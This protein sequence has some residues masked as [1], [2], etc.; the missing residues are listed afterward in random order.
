[1]R[2]D[3]KSCR[4]QTEAVDDD[5]AQRFSDALVS[6]IKAEMGRRDLSSRKL[7]V[8]IGES[9]Q[10]MSMRLDGGNP[11][12]GVRVL[13]NV[14]DIAAIADALGIDAATLMARAAAAAADEPDNVVRG[15]FDVRASPEDE[16]DAVARRSDPEPT[17][18]Q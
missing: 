16:L 12:T 18:E 4:V 13:L 15:R 1:M 8:L 14:R 17:D 7:G 10:Y 2:I 5:S 9:S 6:E 3:E 11:R